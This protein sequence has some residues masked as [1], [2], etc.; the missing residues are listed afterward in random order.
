MSEARK[1]FKSRAK[2]IGQSF[3][4]FQ[5]TPGENI[6]KHIL[7][8]IMPLFKVFESIWYNRLDI[9]PF[10]VYFLRFLIKLC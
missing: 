2:A 10:L 1:R 4:I 6:F 9:V 8:K 7:Q 5:L 3:R